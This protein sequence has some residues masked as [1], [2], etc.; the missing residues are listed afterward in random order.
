MIIFLKFPCGIEKKMEIYYLTMGW[1]RVAKRT[2]LSKYMYFLNSITL[3]QFLL[4]L[5]KN[6]NLKVVLKHCGGEKRKKNTVEKIIG[7]FFYY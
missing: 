1:D 4:K 5:N 3:R 6:K 7:E 2:I